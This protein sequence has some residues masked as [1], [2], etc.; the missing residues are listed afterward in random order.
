[1][2]RAP[3]T[4][5]VTVADDG[6][7]T[8]EVLRQ[9]SKQEEETVTALL[10]GRIKKVGKKMIREFLSG[11]EEY[12]ACIVLAELIRYG[13]LRNSNRLALAALLVSDTRPRQL[14]FRPRR[15]RRGRAG[16]GFDF[17]IAMDIDEAMHN[18][19]K[20][21]IAVAEMVEKYGVSARSVTRAWRKHKHVVHWRTS[22]AVSK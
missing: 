12:F 1:M 13:W 8:W 6:S 17:D 7:E 9:A 20:H 21:D 18:G 4:Y 5:V 16:N 10:E 15:Q 3:G 22:T 11:E 19:L 14:V 2:K